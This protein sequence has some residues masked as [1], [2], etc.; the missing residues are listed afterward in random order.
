MDMEMKMQMEHDAKLVL[1]A[2]LAIALEM[3]DLMAGKKILLLQHSYQISI[4]ISYRITSCLV[5][6]EWSC[7]SSTAETPALSHELQ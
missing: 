4:P 6:H 3:G 1:A 7:R 5:Y 2:G